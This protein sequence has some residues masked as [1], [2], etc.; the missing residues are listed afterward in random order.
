MLADSGTEAEAG[1]GSH[2][3]TTPAWHGCGNALVAGLAVGGIVP[4]G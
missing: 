4:G 3:A 1:A 2:L